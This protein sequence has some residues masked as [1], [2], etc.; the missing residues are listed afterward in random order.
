[1]YTLQDKEFCID[2]LEMIT[3]VISFC[4]S[5]IEELKHLCIDTYT[6]VFTDASSL[7]HNTGKRIEAFTEKWEDDSENICRSLKTI[8]EY[9]SYYCVTLYNSSP[10]TYHKDARY[11]IDS[12][13]TS[14]LALSVKLKKIEGN[15]K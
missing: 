12:L 8:K 13:K 6:D 3:G 14:K 11:I 10:S 9:Y 4:E 1:M 15:I 5:L 7:I 2:S